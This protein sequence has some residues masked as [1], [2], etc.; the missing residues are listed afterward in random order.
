LWHDSACKLKKHW[1]NIRWF[2]G[3]QQRFFIKNRNRTT[4]NASPFP[5]SP[6]TTIPFSCYF[7]LTR[8]WCWLFFE[9]IDVV[10]I[11][12]E[13]IFHFEEIFTSMD[14]VKLTITV[15]SRGWRTES[16]TR[17]WIMVVVEFELEWVKILVC[18]QSMRFISPCIIIA[19]RDRM[20]PS[21]GNIYITMQEV[22]SGSL[23]RTRTLR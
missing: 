21:Q 20:T 10:V 7:Y 11:D 2:L 16:G 17:Q 3:P 6:S 13:D 19:V 9:W 22:S 4:R 12:D 1:V 15:F 5:I 8:T 23:K 14:S 18:W